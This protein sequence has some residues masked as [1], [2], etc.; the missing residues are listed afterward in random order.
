MLAD[1]QTH[2]L[3]RSKSELAHFAN[4]M[5]HAEPAGLCAAL[6]ALQGSIAIHTEHRI[7]QSPADHTA[8]HNNIL[9]DDYD[10]LVAWLE[11]NGFT[12]PHDVA[13]TLS[14]WMAGRIA[15]TRSERAD[16][17]KQSNA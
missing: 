11:Q 4:F 5:G 16:F 13:D 17:A 9:L 10:W 12:R 2:S 6:A 7:L 15:A 14:G 8:S 3:P 1:S